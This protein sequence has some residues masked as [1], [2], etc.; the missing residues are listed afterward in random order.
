MCGG[1]R[2]PIKKETLKVY[3]PN[4]YAQLP[5][6]MKDGNVSL[7]PW[8]RRKEQEGNLPLGGWAR[9]DSINAGKWEYVHPSPVKIA[10]DALW[11]K[12]TIKTLTG[13]I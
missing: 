5:I 6:L 10:V 7:L 1:I 8:G 3:F 13:L 4:P 12:T 2:Y 11:R 9:L